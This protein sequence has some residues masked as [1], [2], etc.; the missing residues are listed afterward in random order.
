MSLRRALEIILPLE[1]GFSDN[2]DDPGN[3]TGGKKGRG[4]LKGTK[5]GISAAQY[6]DLDIENLTV[7]DAVPIYYNDYWHPIDASLLRWPLSLFY[8]DAAINHGSDERAHFAAQKLLQGVLRVKVDG[9]VG[10]KTKAAMLAAEPW[11]A[12]EFLTARSLRYSR[13]AN[14]DKFG[15][16]WLNRL[17]KLVLESRK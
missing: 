6:P 7:D 4:E 15:R 17:F 12:V 9:I 16:G 11:H 1:A 2:P 10:P 14:F 13:T 8:F 5:W 3:W